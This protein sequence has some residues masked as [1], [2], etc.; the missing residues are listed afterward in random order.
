VVAKTDSGLASFD[1]VVAAEKGGKQIRFGTMS[2]RLGD[3]AYLLGKA[4][5]IEFN[6]VSLKGGKAVMNALNAGDV[7]I[8]WGAGVQTKAVLAGDMVN[9]VSG[10]PKPLDVSPD[11]P[12]MKDL[13]VDYD[14][15]AYFMIVGPGGMADDARNALAE[16]LAGV[17]ENPDSKAGGLIKKAFGGSFILQGADLDAR[18]AAESEGAGVLMK[19]SE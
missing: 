5:D 18:L 8:G 1:D 7:D 19:A 12:L 15:G 16:K 9:L 11:A 10:I 13:G 14:A 3:L 4:H 6:I 17:A 2:P